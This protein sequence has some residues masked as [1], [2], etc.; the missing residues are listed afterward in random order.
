MTPDQ[1]A[2]AV[3]GGLVFALILEGSTREREPVEH[4]VDQLLSDAEVEVD[5]DFDRFIKRRCVEL[6]QIQ[7]DAAL[8]TANGFGDRI[9]GRRGEHV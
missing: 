5:L 3:L 6:T 8:I 9:N 4:V 1:I 7:K 2:L